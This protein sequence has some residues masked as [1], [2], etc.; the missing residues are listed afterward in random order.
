M[1]SGDST[2]C[3]PGHGLVQVEFR[4]RHALG[5]HRL[6]H[7]RHRQVG[8]RIH[9][10]LQEEVVTEST[11]G[12]EQV[13]GDPRPPLEAARDERRVRRTGIEDILEDV[14]SRPAVAGAAGDRLAHPTPGV[15]DVADRFADGNPVELAEG[16]VG[17][18]VEGV[19]RRRRFR[20]DRI[21]LP[22]RTAFDVVCGLHQLAAIW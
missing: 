15:P 10:R 9:A 17:I 7:E 1:L 4:V 2:N 11:P 19:A 20:R 21:E 22:N 6:A 13:V 18:A 5:H 14:Q 16:R 12:P 8:A 3:P